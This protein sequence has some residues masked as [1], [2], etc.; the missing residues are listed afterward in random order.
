MLADWSVECSAEDPVL[1]V[2][3]KDPDGKAAFVDLRANPYDFDSIPEAEQNPPLMHALRALNAARSPVFTAKCDAWPLGAEELEH[4]RL[5]LD[6]PPADAPAGFASY[7]DLVWRERSL[8]LSLPQHEQM[9]RR[10]ARLA[11]PLDHPAAVLDCVV[12][13]AF[14]NL[15]GPQQGYAW[16]L[17]VKALGENPQAAWENWGTALDAVVAL[18]RGKELSR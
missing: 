11:V 2:P 16:S 8:F 15:G 14:L 13:P 5:E 3:W 10:L 4:L 12:R 6:V 18:I 9:L 17:Y 7:I 1:V